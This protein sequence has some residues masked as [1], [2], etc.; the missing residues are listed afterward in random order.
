MGFGMS[1]RAFVA[2]LAPALQVQV[3]NPK[4]DEEIASGE[5]QVR[6]HNDMIL[7]YRFSVLYFTRCGVRSLPNFSVIIVS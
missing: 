1:L 3:S 7:I 6:P 2:T 4:L 5:E